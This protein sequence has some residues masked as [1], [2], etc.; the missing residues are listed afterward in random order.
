MPRLSENAISFFGA[1]GHKHDGVSS[2]LISTATYSLFDFN[3]GYIGSQSRISIQ[4][5]NQTALEEWVMNIVNTKVLAPAGLDLAPGLLSGKSIRANTITATEL[6]ANTI[7]ASEIAAGTI[8]ANELSSNIVLINNRITS[9]NW[10]GTIQANGTI[11]SNNIGSAGWAITNTHAVFDSTLIRG[12]IAANSLVTPNLTISNTGAITSTNFNVT[13]G[14]NVTAVNATITGAINASSGSFT[15]K[16][17]VPGTQTQFGTNINDAANYQGIKIGGIAG[18]WKNAWVERN[19]GSV[20]FNA[21]NPAGTNRFYMDSTD[22]LL[23]MGNGAFIVN[24]AG[25]LTATSGSISGTVTIG[26]TTASTVVANAALGGSAAQPGSVNG[27]VTS[28]DGSTITTGTINLNNLNVRTGTSGARINLDSGGL[29]AYNSAGTQTVKIG[30][31]GSAT[32]TGSVTGSTISGSTLTSGVW[33]NASATGLKIDSF[34]YITGAGGGVKIR[35]FGSNGE[36]GATGTILFGDSITVP[37]LYPNYIQLNG[38][39][40]WNQNGEAYI[41]GAAIRPLSLDR[42]FATG[43]AFVRFNNVSGGSSGA[44]VAG[45][46]KYSGATGLAISIDYTSDARLKEN[47]K[48]VENAI[49]KIKNISPRSFNFIGDD[50]TVDGFVAQELYEVYPNSVNIGGEDPREDPWGVD[51]ASITPIITAALKESI[52]KIEELEARIQ[53]LEGV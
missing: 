45:S 23:S 30:S 3:P 36:D 21:Q 15:G 42:T 2:T 16:I 38:Y 5:I 25:Q 37:N 1:G 24:N 9:Q 48:D 49:V 22:S 51:Y 40:T 43:G 8:T 44:G 4:Q 27:L 12:S 34:G 28:I 13:A 50:T 29:Y 33:S 6:Q 10:N 20:Y 41:G 14:G 17:T 47:I 39:N 46:I 32:F 11:F 26:G 7:T 19:D 31:D 18:E 52:A 35:N 53:T